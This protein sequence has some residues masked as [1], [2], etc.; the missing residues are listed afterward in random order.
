MS[1]GA[2]TTRTTP[3]ANHNITVVGYAVLGNIH[4][5]IPDSND[6]HPLVDHPLLFPVLVFHTGESGNIVR[7]GTND[8]N[9]NEGNNDTHTKTTQNKIDHG[10]TGPWA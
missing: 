3:C 1:L 5:R 9:N 8:D 2:T 10:K 6:N 4:S 7:G